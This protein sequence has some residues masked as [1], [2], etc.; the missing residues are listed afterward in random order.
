MDLRQQ[1]TADLRDS[2]RAGDQRRKLAIRAVRA[3]ITNAEIERQRPLTE[4]EILALVAKEVKQRHDSIDQFQK[5]GRQDLVAQEQAEI[6]ALERY[7]PRQLS[8]EEIRVEAQRI[9]AET[10]AASP[11]DMGRV[12]RELIPAMRGRAAGGLVSQIVRELLTGQG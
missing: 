2:M 8:A 11:R 9:I 6:E 4:D 3:A 7:L 5:G 10:E 12:M 1:L